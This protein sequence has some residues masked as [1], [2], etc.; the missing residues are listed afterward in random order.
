MRVSD[1]TKF[2][3]VRDSI[4]SSKGRLDK[5]QNEMATLKKVNHPSDDPV[6][7]IKILEIRTDKMN[8]DQFFK[9]AKFAE[10]T[11]L[12]ADSVLESLVETVSRAKEIALS[13]S[14]TPSSTDETRLGVSEE[15]N[16]L[17]QRA[18]ALANTRI[19]DRY[20]FGGYRVDRPPVTEE[21][22]YTGD[23]GHMMLEIARGVYIG[24]N[25]PGIEVFNSQPQNS[26]DASRLYGV[27]RQLASEKMKD[28]ETLPGTGNENVNLFGELA[29]LRVA[30]LTGDIESVHGTLDRLDQIH[31]SLVA[32]RS[33]IGSRISGLQ[34]SL[35]STD[36]QGLIQA[37]LKQN[38]EDADLVEVMN[39]MS[40]NESVFRSVLSSSQK[41]VQP[42]LMD[43]L[44]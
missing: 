30:L 39:D 25:V 20:L 9:N 17:F 29:G 31:T 21:G 44:K 42:S 24:A 41:L 28:V 5:A 13:Q 11:L 16:Q 8:N 37:G 3:T 35:Q 36:R 32:N 22:T 18:V 4:Q 10:S 34:G 6:G 43:F 26:G 23:D 19:A 40:R 1:N 27:D 14:S 7:S 12:H 38:I 15:V 2:N 33:K